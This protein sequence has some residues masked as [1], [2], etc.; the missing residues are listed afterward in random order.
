M[1]AWGA[2][3]P[4]HVPIDVSLLRSAST[5]LVTILAAVWRFGWRDHVTER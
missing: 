2:A 4:P 1:Q 3:R 5:V